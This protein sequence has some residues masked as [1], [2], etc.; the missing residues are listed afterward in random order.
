MDQAI[1]TGDGVATR[2]RACARA[3]LRAAQSYVRP[4]TKPVAGTVRVAVSGVPL[5]AGAGFTVDLDDGQVH[6]VDAAGAGGAGDRRVRVRRAGAFRQRS[7]QRPASPASRRARSRRSRSWRCGS[8]ARDRPGLAGAAGWRRDAA[9]PLLAWCAAATAARSGSPT[10]TGTSRFDAVGVPGEQRDGRERAA[11]GDRPERGQRPGGRGAEQR[12][13][14]A[15][16][17]SGRGG[18]TARRSA[19]W[20][21]DWERPELRVLMFRGSSRRDPPVGRRL[22]GGAARA[23]G[24][25]ERAGGPVGAADLRPGARGREVRVRREPAGVLG[26]GRRC[27]AWRGSVITAGGLGGFAAGW[28]THGALTWLTGANAGEKA[29]VKVDRPGEAGAPQP[30]ALAG[31]GAE[32][33]GGRPVPGGGRAATSVPRPAGRSSAT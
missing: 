29:S 4:V 1:G 33:R 24:G 10:T 23:G 25:A 15:R 32:A 27:R 14:S 16:R 12:R 31:A 13:R 30:D 5:A 17:T 20:L 11:V 26:R 28:F 21:V 18:T 8:D 6:L 9:L 22:R 2:I 19:Q 3:M 7:D